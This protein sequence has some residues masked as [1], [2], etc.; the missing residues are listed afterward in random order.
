MSKKSAQKSSVVRLDKASIPD[1][2]EVDD[3]ERSPADQFTYVP[4]VAAELGRDTSK[5]KAS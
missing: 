5:K 1:R 2:P 3:D 4:D